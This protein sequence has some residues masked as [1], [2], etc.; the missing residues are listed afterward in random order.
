M[1]RVLAVIAALLAMVVPAAALAAWPE[2]P[3]K[4]VVPFPPGGATD[5]IGRVIAQELSG[6]IGQ[7]VVVD[8]RPGATG[9]IGADLVAK[10]AP[11]GYTLLLGAL[12]SH[13]I[14]ATLQK[15]LPYDLERDFTPVSLAGVVPLVFVVHPSVPANTLP[16]LIA[17]AKA[18]PGYLTF[19]S[20]G[21]GGPQ[22]LAGE[23]FKR[24]AGVDMLHVPYKGSGPAMT[25][26]MGG[27]VLTMIETAP[28]A[29]PFIKSQRLRAIAAA[30]THRIPML[31]DVPSAAEAGLPGFEVNSMFGLLAPV[32]TPQP[33]VARLNAEVVKILQ[34]QGV[35]DKMM[36]QG[37]IATP[38]T[39][40]E[41][42]QRIHAE[43]A[44][45]AQVIREAGVKSTD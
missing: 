1:K 28:A 32:N 36:E 15:S 7:Q 16:E 25:D 43:I 2:R 29:L 39:P 6:V 19:A 13:A 37:A 24:M 3:I 34:K 12:T 44:K 41:A 17:L 4:L 33:I 11:D 21:N 45:W 5:V 38:T 14:N 9:N 27:Q 18:K 42:K 35:K 10:A 8:N 22:H 40:A 20:S 23:L 30:S 26:L 31:P